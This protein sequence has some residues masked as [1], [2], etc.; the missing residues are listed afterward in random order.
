[1]RARNL[2][3]V[4]NIRGMVVVEDRCGV[5]K[6]SD[7]YRLKNF[8][9]PRC[10][11]NRNIW[12]TDVSEPS[13]CVHTS[14]T[15]PK[16]TNI[17]M[18]FVALISGGK[19]SFYNIA[20][21]IKNGHELSALANLL[22]EDRDEVDS[23]MFQTVGHNV[24]A[25]YL[26]CLSVPLYRR[27]LTRGS[28]Y[29]QLEYEPTPNDEIEDLYELLKEVKEAHPDIEGVSCGA[30]LSH[31]QRT[32][33][34][35]VCER[36]G[37]T[38][39]AYLWQR[40]QSELVQEMCAYGL[41]ARIIK[42]AALGLN[43]THL[44][45]SLAQL[46]PLLHKLNTMY[47]VHIAGE[48]GEFETLVMDAPFFKK[49]LAITK[50]EVVALSSDTWH[51]KVEVEIHD[52]EEETIV[53]VAVP[54]ILEPQFED[55]AADQ[56]SSEVD[57]PTIAPSPSLFSLSPVI[58]QTHIS[59]LVSPMPTLAS[60]TKQIFDLA[61]NILAASGKSFRDIQHTTLLLADMGDFQDVNAIYG[62]Y[63]SGFPLPPS[64][65]CVQSVLPDPYR[66]QVSFS[67]LQGSK[68]GI[69]IRLRSYWAPQNIGPYS[70]AIVD[71]QRHSKVASLLGQIPL[72]PSLMEAASSR[73][74]TNSVL[75][76]QHLFRV[77]SVVGVRQL[78]QVT[79]FVTST[80]P[81]L[82]SLVWLSYVDQVEFGQDF[83]KRLVIVQVSGLPRAS[84]VEWGGVAFEK[85]VDELSDDENEEPEAAHS[86][87]S[88]V[89]KMGDNRFLDV[90]ILNSFQE[91]FSLLTEPAISEKYVTVM[92]CLENIHK[93]ANL[94]LR[95]EWMPVLNVFDSQGER[96]EFAVV[97]RD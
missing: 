70:Q 92:T 36:L 1:M 30:I 27:V 96:C 26:E 51:L 29:V 20:H 54:S 14:I 31:Y 10:R 79:C 33:V 88:V 15:N 78:A 2:W 83:L 34:E 60:Q 56:Q 45:Q 6:F 5:R 89:V 24:I 13:C 73:H 49:K 77:K 17:D 68:S 9:R 74:V 43:Q 97:V 59:N 55:I 75:S 18:K 69:H 66:L 61:C 94:G 50:S 32:R 35:N 23:F 38:A 87:D 12:C 8:S 11:N 80:S 44:G 19:D 4:P 85:V 93:L 65:V 7:L 58:S 84:T 64:R 62:K 16:S 71:N 76:L 41:D 95:A 82:V 39:L 48:G 67:L 91:V 53:E 90:R 52:K 63:F 25:K 72:L 57:G 40:D 47:E 37:L 28:T 22:P 81:K 46:S 3:H 86:E 21:C 42:V